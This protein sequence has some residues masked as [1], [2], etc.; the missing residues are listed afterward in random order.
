MKIIK[1]GTNRNDTSKYFDLLELNDIIW[2]QPYGFKTLPIPMYLTNKKVTTKVLTFTSMLSGYNAPIV[3]KSSIPD[4][5]KDS[6]A[7]TT[8]G[9]AIRLKPK[10]FEET[11]QILNYVCTELSK[12]ANLKLDA[13]SMQQEIIDLLT[14]PK[15][16]AILTKFSRGS[17]NLIPAVQRQIGIFLFKADWKKKCSHIELLAGVKEYDLAGVLMEK[18]MT[19]DKFELRILDYVTMYERRDQLTKEMSLVLKRNNGY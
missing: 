14:E 3:I 10:V 6:G 5:L 2:H 12:K 13:Q 9:T 11:K 19:S 8:Y 4:T 15:L 7:E 1:I 18:G 17:L 16:S